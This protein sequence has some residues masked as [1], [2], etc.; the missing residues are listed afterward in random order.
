MIEVRIDKYLW[1]VR[2]YKTRALSTEACHLEKISI[3]NNTV[4]PSRNIKI[5]DTFT[6]KSGSFERTFKVIN[7]VKN[8]LPASKV[9]EYCVE[10]TAPEIA[11]AIK[12]FKAARAAWREPGMGRP[13]KKERR[14]L[15]DF[16]DWE[17][18]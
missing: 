4:K 8:R 14:E 1:A 3:G 18:W 10:T 7:V 13:T 16:M 12:T 15:D 6:V 2:I 9:V 5:G 17:E 11:E